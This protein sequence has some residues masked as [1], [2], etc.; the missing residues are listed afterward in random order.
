MIQIFTTGGTIDKVYFDALSE[1]QIGNP[2]VG[3][4]LADAGVA[5]DY[6][7]QSLLRKDS[8]ELDDDDRAQLRAAVVAAPA[9]KVL[10]THGTD[11]MVDTGLALSDIEGKTIVLVGAMQPAGL[12]VTDA[13]FNIGF[14]WAALQ[15][16]PAGVYIAMNGRLFDPHKARKNRQAHRFERVG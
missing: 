15:T 4:V 5:D 1:F 8:L 11:T 7:V 3:R 16:L 12:R 10:I 13:E 9:T 6:A 2:Q 14:A